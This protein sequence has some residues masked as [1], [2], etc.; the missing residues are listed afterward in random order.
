MDMNTEKGMLECPLCGQKTSP[1]TAVGAHM[2]GEFV[3][4]CQD[5]LPETAVCDVC[6]ERYLRSELHLTEE[7]GWICEKCVEN[8]DEYI[9]CEHCDR[10]ASRYSAVIC[11]DE[12]WGK[13]CADNF[14]VKCEECGSWIKRYDSIRCANGDFICQSCYESDYVTCEECGDAILLENAIVR[15]DYYY[16]ENCAPS[17][18]IYEYH[19]FDTGNYRDKR[20]I[21]GEKDDLYLGIELECDYGN[22]DGDV[23]SGYEE[24]HFEEDGSLSSDGVEMISLPMTLR[25]H[26]RY[27]WERILSLLLN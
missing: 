3:H 1:Y 2:D 23:F 14:L 19:G 9:Y 11:D 26:Q 6:G 25:Y 16:C 27:D 17:S 12:W 24:I 18:D 7:E 22:F 10:Y 5:C 15:N 13:K 8:S 21:K 4:I 20:K